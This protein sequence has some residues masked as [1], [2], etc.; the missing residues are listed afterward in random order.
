MQFVYRLST[1]LVAAGLLAGSSAFA[2]SITGTITFVGT[3]PVMKEI[4]TS[5]DPHCAE[6]HKDSDPL[7]NE[8]LVLGDG[9]TMG[10]I[11]V[12]V[13]KGLPE[14]KTYPVPAEPLV[15]TQHGCKYSPHVSV[16]MAG[17]TIKFLNPD[18]ILH[19]VNAAPTENTP[20]NKA[21][22]ASM[23]EMEQVLDKVEEPF[24]IRCD[25]HQWMNAYVE[26]VDNPFYDITEADGK[27]TID[28]LEAGEY[29]ISVWHE[30]LKSQTFTVTVPAEGS[31]TQDASFELPKK[32]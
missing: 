15:L 22:P 20:F 9:Q 19:N 25:I 23:E 17:Q 16:A 29:E 31:V 5:A 3:P 27:Y 1:G 28:G 2:G 6:M 21:M 12:K 32:K 11:I 8:A 14:G 13:T 26:V 4:N 24:M 10:N 18:K 30:K 7:V